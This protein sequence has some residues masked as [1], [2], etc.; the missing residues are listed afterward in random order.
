MEQKFILTGDWEFEHCPTPYKAS[1]RTFDRVDFIKYFENEK[2]LKDFLER[3]DP[4]DIFSIKI[5]R[6]ESAIIKLQ[7]K[8]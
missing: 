8:A 3:L 1:W 7:E 6:T 5:T 4:K 2:E